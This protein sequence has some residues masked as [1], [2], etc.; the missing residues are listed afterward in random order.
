MNARSTMFSSIFISLHSQH[1]CR[2]VP[3]QLYTK[4]VSLL[5]LLLLSMLVISRSMDLWKIRISSLC[6]I[7]KLLFTSF[8]IF[9]FLLYQP[10]S[11]VSQITKELCFCSSYSF[12]F[13]H[14]SNGIME[15]STLFTCLLFFFIC[16]HLFISIGLKIYCSFNL[17]ILMFHLL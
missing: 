15:A 9:S 5:L 17:P 11:F 1:F 4:S 8:S 10:I 7:D 13:N 6:W 16:F 2:C 12:H 14:L 3:V